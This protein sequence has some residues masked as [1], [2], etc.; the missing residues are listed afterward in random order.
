[1]VYEFMI[2]PEQVLAGAKVIER[3]IEQPIP[4]SIIP[5]PDWSP[6]E[7][8]NQTRDFISRHC[9]FTKPCHAVVL[10]LWAMHTYLINCFRYTPYIYLHSPT[11]ECGKTRVLEV[12]QLLCHESRKAAD[13]TESAIFRSIDK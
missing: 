12:L 10:A 1:M 9:V 2:T 7:V 4:A 11:M 8:F 5:F 6:I 3:E 13:M